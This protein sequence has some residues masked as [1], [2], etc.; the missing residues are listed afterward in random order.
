MYI[1]VLLLNSH[2]YWKSYTPVLGL[3]C[4]QGMEKGLNLQWF[5]NLETRNIFFA[6]PLLYFYHFL[7]LVIR[8]SHVSLHWDK[9]WGLLDLVDSRFLSILKFVFSLSPQMPC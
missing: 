1:L 7:L 6:S 3:T 8:D 9:L 5:I 4:K 2:R